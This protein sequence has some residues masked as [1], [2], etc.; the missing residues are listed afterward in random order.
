MSPIAVVGLGVCTNVGVSPDEYW[1]GLN[2]AAPP[3]ARPVFD[4]APD[5]TAPTYP[6]ADLPIDDRLAAHEL[7]RLDR[8]HRIALSAAEDAMRGHD[9]TSGEWAVC[10][11]TGLGAGPFSEEQSDRLRTSGPRGLSPMTVPLMMPNSVAAHLALEHGVR[12]PVLTVATACASG[13]NAIGEAM[14]MLRAGRADAVLA[15]GVDSLLYATPLLGFSR[16]GALSTSEDDTPSRPFDRDR[17]GFVM[18]EGGAFLVLMRDDDAN[19]QGAPVLGRLLG[20]AA[21]DDG[22]HLV[23]P[24]SDGA[25]AAECMRRALRDADL[26]PGDVGHVNAHGTS[27]ELNDVAEAAAIRT[28]FGDGGPPVTA[29]KG[30]SG[31]MI[32]GSGATEVAATLL[33]CRHGSVPPTG[34]VRHL[35]ERVQIDVVHGE[36]RSVRSR[37]GLSNSFAFGGHNASIVVSA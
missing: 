33:S 29:P 27:T 6:I 30:V 18:G 16:L 13:A 9:T 2:T 20:Y 21:N 34:G 14:W 25:G 1:A 3:V 28:V 22:H 11:G 35:D 31:H 10:V 32:G 5:W 15:G 37:I 7:R 8:P 26:S 12:G 4:L 17:D 24:L 19:A 36:P 23:A